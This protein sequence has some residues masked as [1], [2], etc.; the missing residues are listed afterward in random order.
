[1]V[2][3]ECIENRQTDIERPQAISYNESIE[4]SIFSRF[5]TKEIVMP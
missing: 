4:T 5:I 3:R 2:D 1:M